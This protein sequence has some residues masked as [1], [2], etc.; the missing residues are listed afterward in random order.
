M[1]K[2]RDVIS[3]IEFTTFWSNKKNCYITRTTLLRTPTR[4]EVRREKKTH[5]EVDARK[6]HLKARL[7]LDNMMLKLAE[8]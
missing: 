8:V 1:I 2:L 5:T 7:A 6:A 4:R 3:D